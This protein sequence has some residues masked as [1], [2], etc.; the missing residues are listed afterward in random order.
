MASGGTD[1]AREATTTW[2][3]LSLSVS[4]REKRYVV[5]PTST[6]ERNQVALLELNPTTGFKHQLRLTCAHK[7][8]STHP[9]A[10][11]ELLLYSKGLMLG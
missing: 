8:G 2:R 6:Q 9:L 7:L 1:G 5:V 3:V 11:V 4:L 10:C